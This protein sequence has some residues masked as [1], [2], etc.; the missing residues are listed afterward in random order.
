M[1]NDP[2]IRM[3]GISKS[4]YGVQVL[5]D[6]NLDIYE[7]EIHAICG[8]NG[9]GKSTLMNI[10]TG[11][12]Q[13]DSGD[14]FFENKRVKFS[15]PKDAQKI[16]IGI[17]H[18]ELSLFPHLS[19][20]EN[21]FAGRLIVNSRGIVDK[22]K[23]NEVT[24][25][26]LE[27]L[28]ADIDP[29]AIVGNLSISQ[30]QIVEI[31]KAISMDCRV[32]VL[33]EP[34][35]ALTDAEVEN[36]FKVLSILKRSG[37]AILY[38]SHKMNE[39]FKICERCTVLRDGVHV[40]TKKISEITVDEVVSSMVGRKLESIYPPK[41]ERRGDVKL[42]VNGLTRNGV[43]RDISFKLYE[44][45]ILGLF[46]LI[47]AGRTEIAR[48]ICGIDRVDR[49]EV[50]LLGQ[51]IPLNNVRSSIKNGLVYITEDRKGEGLF[52][53]KSVREN[54]IAADFKQVSR[55]GLIQE[56][57]VSKISQ[58][59]K[60]KLGIKCRDINQRVINLSGGNQQKVL[61]SRWLAVDPQVLLLD[62]PTRGI[63]VGAKHEI[64]ELLR[65]LANEGR[66]IIV[67][68]SDLPEILGI[69]D[70][71]LVIYQGEITGELVAK[72]ASEEMVMQYA[73][74]RKKDTRPLHI[75]EA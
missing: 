20:L 55:K 15:E 47:G 35:S 5:K 26:I 16:G 25:E 2:L 36:L 50:R 64:H 29:E 42:E 75:E 8:E 3:K 46:G 63:D 56:G 57:A 33:D 34:T 23:M 1:K 52:L 18:Q 4:F 65:R 53:Q 10:L 22:R 21:I 43:Y 67:I 72:D 9:A 62:E 40:W 71:I 14:I 48:G 49:G 58:E 37:I 74:G 54:I 39:I 27:K 11:S 60:E 13:P 28:N 31:A 51:K 6:I 61:L 44:G 70:R 69:S 7:G 73:T 66:G 19:V 30:Q 41:S 45:E 68:S 38:I 24:K 12:L 32:L 59:F 17:V